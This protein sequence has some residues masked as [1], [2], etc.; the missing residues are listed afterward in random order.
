MTEHEQE[1]KQRQKHEHEHEHEHEHNIHEPYRRPPKSDHHAKDVWKGIGLTALLH[2]LLLVY[3]SAYLTIGV[4]QLIYMLPAIIITSRKN[5]GIMQGLL[6]GLGVTFL[7]NAACFGI[8][9]ATF[10]G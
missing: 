6:I 10:S 1:L 3:P 8:V 7:L 4:V 9:M 5:T 2:L